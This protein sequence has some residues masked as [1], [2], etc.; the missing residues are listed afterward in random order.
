MAGLYVK[1]CVW[2]WQGG[3]DVAAVLTA[4]GRW[5]ASLAPGRGPSVAEALIGS[6]GGREGEKRVRSLQLWQFDL[7]RAPGHARMQWS[8][9]MVSLAWSCTVAAVDV[10]TEK[11]ALPM[12]VGT[13]AEGVLR[14]C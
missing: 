7:P 10:Q 3:E 11:A 4:W 8:G 9:A 14:L 6:L 12:F 1:H 5:Q 13:Q 2:V